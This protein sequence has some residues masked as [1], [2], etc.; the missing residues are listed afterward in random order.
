MVTSCCAI[1]CTFRYEK[2]S[3][4][5]IFRIPKDEKLRKL[6]I[7]AIKRDNWTPTASSRI[8]GQHFHTGKDLK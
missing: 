1:G 2:G 6:W 7:K 5:G 8:C 4:I 3:Q